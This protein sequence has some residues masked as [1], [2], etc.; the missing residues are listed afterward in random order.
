MNFGPIFVR[1]ALNSLINRILTT[2]HRKV[3]FLCG[4]YILED[5]PDGIT[6]K[7]E[8]IAVGKCDISTESLI[9]KSRYLYLI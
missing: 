1:L 8:D 2:L 7:T 4:Y 5:N 9:T 6:L 3:G